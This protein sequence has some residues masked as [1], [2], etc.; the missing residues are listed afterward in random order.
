[1]HRKLE[2]S[3]GDTNYRLHAT[4]NIKS[5]YMY[6]KICRDKS[7][8]ANNQYN[9]TYIHMQLKLIILGEIKQV[10]GATDIATDIATHLVI[11]I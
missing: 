2:E 4:R 8:F 6:T 11:Y 10:I 7:I 5:T 1:M 9:K 3:N